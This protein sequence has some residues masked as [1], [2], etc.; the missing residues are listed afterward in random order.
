MQVLTPIKKHS[1]TRAKKPKLYL[2]Y[3]YFPEYESWTYD[4]FPRFTSRELKKNNP[5]TKGR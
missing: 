4:Y 1:T 5:R 2:K 3:V